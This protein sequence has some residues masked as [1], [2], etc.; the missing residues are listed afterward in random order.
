MRSTRQCWVRKGFPC[1]WEGRWRTSC[2]SEVLKLTQELSRGSGQSSTTRLTRHT[3]AMVTKPYSC[4]WASDSVDRAWPDNA[5]FVANSA[6]L[7]AASS[8]LTFKIYPD[9]C[10]GVQ[11][12]R[13]YDI[14]RQTRET[15][16][17]MLHWPDEC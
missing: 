10:C 16:E 4:R 9:N 17:K 1:D 7:W 15:D 6:A 2:V 5:N 14:L 3:S 12:C 8:E 13:D 11:Y